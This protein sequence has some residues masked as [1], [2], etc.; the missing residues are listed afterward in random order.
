M[1]FAAIRYGLVCRAAVANTPAIDGLCLEPQQFG[2]NFSYDTP[3]ENRVL[4]K[5]LSYHLEFA[6][7]VVART[8]SEKNEVHDDVRESIVAAVGIWFAALH[9]NRDVLDAEV[10]AYL[11]TLLTRSQNYVMMTPPQVV[12]LRCPHTAAFAF[13]VHDQTLT[14]PFSITQRRGRAK[15]AL[16]QTPGRTILLNFEAGCWKPSN[17]DALY[18]AES[19]CLNATAL[20]AHELGHA[21][22]LQHVNE[23]DSIMRDALRV[24]RPSRADVERL[25]AKL[26]TSIEGGKPGELTFVGST[27]VDFDCAEGIRRPFLRALRVVKVFEYLLRN[28]PYICPVS[29]AR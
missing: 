2:V 9:Q 3:L 14:G 1:Q 25:S 17:G 20:I 16:A 8:P 5:G 15:L 29:T 21:F 6:D 12:E 18:A 7:D 24:T 26:R 28:A 19:G 27:G 11:D 4:T 13:R 22:G 10:A 23:R